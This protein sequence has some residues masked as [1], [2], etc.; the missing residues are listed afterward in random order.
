MN[1]I[2]G[3]KEKPEKRRTYATIDLFPTTLS[4]MGVDI[5]GDRLGLGTDLYSDTPTLTET[6]GI[7]YMNAQFSMNSE[8]YEKKIL[9]GGK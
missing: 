9:Y 2:N 3:Q 4:A 5:E 1:I 8:F 7:D 6:M